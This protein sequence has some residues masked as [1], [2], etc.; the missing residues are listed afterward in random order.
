MTL[1]ARHILSDVVNTLRLRRH[2][3]D[4]IFKCIF[5]DENVWIPIE[6]SLKFVPRGP[7]NN[8]PALVRIMAWRRLGNMPLSEPRMIS[9]PTHIWVIRPQ[10]V[11][12][13]ESCQWVSARKMEPTPVGSCT[14]PSIQCHHCAIINELI[15]CKNSDISDFFIVVS[16]FSSAIHTN[17][18]EQEDMF[19]KR[20][21]PRK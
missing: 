3:A 20:H 16:D 18:Q 7:I 8:F 4:A 19:Y 21:M 2:F 12:I 10:W 1:L 5:D 11:N 14:N 17:Q 13:S 9:L 15:T 6:I